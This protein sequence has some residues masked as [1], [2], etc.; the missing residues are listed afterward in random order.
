MSVFE[1]LKEQFTKKLTFK[2]KKKKIKSLDLLF[3][4]LTVFPPLTCSDFVL[5]FCRLLQV[6]PDILPYTE[7]SARKKGVHT[8]SELELLYNK[9]VRS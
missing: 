2:K 6:H 5:V 8:L 9:E 1:I 4:P 7:E 3:C